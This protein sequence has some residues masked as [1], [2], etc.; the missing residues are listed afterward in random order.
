MLR[1]AIVSR[2]QILNWPHVGLRCLWS[3]RQIL[4]GEHRWFC[5][6]T[7]SL[8]LCSLGHQEA[9][10]GLLLVNVVAAGDLLVV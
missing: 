5:L 3:W 6:D 10:L 4:L 7:V 2:R 1:P 8:L 9:Q